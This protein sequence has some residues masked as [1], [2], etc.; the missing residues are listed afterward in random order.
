MTPVLRKLS[1]A[2]IPQCR[3]LWTDRFSDTDPFLAWYFQHYFNPSF[4]YGIFEEGSLVSMAH[5]RQYY[6][7]IDGIQYSGLMA[8]GVCTASDSE[9]HGYMRMNMDA[10]LEDAVRE[11][12]SFVCLSPADAKIYEPLGYRT[13]CSVRI[14]H[15]M[16]ECVPKKYEKDPDAEMLHSIYTAFGKQFSLFPDRSVSGMQERIEELMSDGA[17]LYLLSNKAY[18]FYNKKNRLCEEIA[19]TSDNAVRKLL[20]KLPKDCEAVLP[21]SF[22]C[23]GEIRPQLMFLPINSILSE[24]QGTAFCADTF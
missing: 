23:L 1:E 2:D 6:L 22:P 9:R 8:G 14:A 21:A 5:A 20:K 17:K 15:G 24:I 19:G 13:V 7:R 18:A 4:S 11:E 10:I 3:K 16:S 12:F